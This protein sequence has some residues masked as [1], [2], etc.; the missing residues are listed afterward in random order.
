MQKNKKIALITG[1]SRGI[2]KEIAKTLSKNKIFVIGSSKNINGKNI[3]DKQLKHNGFGII[4]DLNN[5]EQ[6][7]HCI[8]NIYNQ[9]KKIDILIHNAAAKNDKLLI[10]MHLCDWNNTF[11]VNLTAIFLITKIIVRNMIKQKYGRVIIISSVSGYTGNIGQINYSAS[12]SGIIGFNKTLALEVASKGIT[13]N[14]IA[15]GFIDIGMTKTMTERQKIKCLSKI[16][17]KKF[18]SAKDIAAIVLF[19]TSK[20]SSYITGQTIHVNG[21]IYMN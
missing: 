3:I 7:S 12:K 15:P 20:Y 11:K 10:N 18:G 21:G 5:L 19:L 13:S 8:Q 9:F 14:V 2:G 1:A 17:M 4:L 6:V 16:P